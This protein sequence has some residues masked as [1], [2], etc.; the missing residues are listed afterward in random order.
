MN[1]FRVCLQEPLFIGY[2]MAGTLSFCALLVYLSTVS[3]FLPDV[4]GVPTGYVGLA[5]A[6]TVT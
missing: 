1:T 6:L 2:Q 3:F 5:F 4:F